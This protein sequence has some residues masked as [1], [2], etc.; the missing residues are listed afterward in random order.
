MGE[1]ISFI[2]TGLL[3]H[4][5]ANRGCT[6]TAAFTG[7]HTD[8]VGVNGAGHTVVLLVIHLGQSVVLIHRLIR[9]ITDSSALDHVS[10]QKASDGLVLRTATCAVHATDELDVATA[11]FV[12][13][14][15]SSFQRHI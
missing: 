3:L 2:C 4:A 12:S 10:H 7:S 11:M 8:D 15:I 9:D 1:K 13:T 5:A 14:M 6:V